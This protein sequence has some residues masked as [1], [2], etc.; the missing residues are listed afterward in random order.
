MALDVSDL[1]PSVDPARLRLARAV[2]AL[3]DLGAGPDADHADPAALDAAA[4]AVEKAV[5]RVRSATGRDPGAPRA[6]RAPLARYAEVL[7]HSSLVGSVS[8]VAPE[9]TWTFTDGVLEVRATFGLLHEGPP[10]SVHGGFVALA[11][12]D[13]LGMT[14]VLSGL[15]GFTGRLTVRYRARTPLHAE[16]RLR[17]FV[18][19][20]E[21]RRTVTRGEL[22]HDDTLC[23][24]AEGLFVRTSFTHEA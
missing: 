13:A 4:A 15:G 8:A 1:D 23:A 10:G 20:H 22:W 18:D 2:R 9:S 21:G 7:P 12:D 17:A 3:L 16:V 14:N 5:A 24:E 6:P 11:F 19:H